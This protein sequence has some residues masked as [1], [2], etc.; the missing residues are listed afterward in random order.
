M[1]ALNPKLRAWLLPGGAFTLAAVL[2][3]LVP[4]P[5]TLVVVRELMRDARIRRRMD[6]TTWLVLIGLGTRLAT[7]G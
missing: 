6:I 4:R 5:D 7:D 1:S 2:V 3:V